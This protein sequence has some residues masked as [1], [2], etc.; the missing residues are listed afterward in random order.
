MSSILNALRKV[1]YDK[2]AM[3]QGGVDLAHDILRRGYSEPKTFPVS[4]VVFAGILL[5]LTVAGGFWYFAAFQQ[6]VSSAV[7]EELI[8]AEVVSTE[9]AETLSPEISRFPGET[10]SE[11]DVIVA[12]EVDLAPVPA[13]VESVPALVVAKPIIIPDL[14][15]D[16]IVYH[17]RPTARLAVING[18]PVMEGTDIEGARIEKIL[19]DQ[20]LF[21]YQG[22]R[23]SK[24]KTAT[25]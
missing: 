18:L 9:Q 13:E 15:V 12:S 10:N 8:G 25:E 21:F 16:E 1:E 5:V 22:I 20:V 23:F 24:Y 11:H 17:Q 19:S 7:V 14:R 4:L 6:P 2:A 3:G